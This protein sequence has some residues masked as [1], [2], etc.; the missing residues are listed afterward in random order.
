MPTPGILN[1]TFGILEIFIPKHNA[2]ESYSGRERYPFLLQSKRLATVKKKRR[3]RGD[4]TSIRSL[5][6]DRSHLEKKSRSDRGPI[7][8]P[9]CPHH[10]KFPCASKV[11]T[12]LKTLV[13]ATYSHE[14]WQMKVQ[15]PQLHLFPYK[16]QIL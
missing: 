11:C 13:P 6:P 7:K 15:D 1:W 12:S 14:I 8:F 2:P 16:E 5:F 10:G 9:P 4:I 3:S